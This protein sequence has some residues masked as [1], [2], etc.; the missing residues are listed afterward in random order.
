MKDRLSIHV[1]NGQSRVFEAVTV[2]RNGG[3]ASLSG[4][5]GIT[6]QT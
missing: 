5:V 6:N 1:E 2:L 4:L 3:T